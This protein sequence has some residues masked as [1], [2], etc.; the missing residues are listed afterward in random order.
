MESKRKDATELRD[1]TFMCEMAFLCDITSHLNVMNLQLQ[2][3]GR[4]ISD[5][6]ST[7]TAFQTKLSLWE[8]QM[9]KETLS[10]FPSCQTTKEKRSTAQHT[11]RRVPTPIC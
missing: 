2:G 8:T 5:M 9:Q 11:C 1:E 6:C 10:H 7:V 3:R 4:V